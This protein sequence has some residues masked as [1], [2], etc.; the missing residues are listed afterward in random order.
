MPF[1]R[2]L[3]WAVVPLCLLCTPRWGAAKKI[4]NL[5]QI[6]YPSDA[7]IPWEC[8]TLKKGDSPLKLFG[9]R[10]PEVLRF[11]RIDRRH[12][13][14]GLSLKVP[15]DLEALADF[16]PLPR[17]Y[18]EAALAEKY[19]LVDL[20]E[21]YLGAYEYGQLRFS[22]PIASGG[23]ETPTPNGDF[24]ITAYHRDH[25]SSLYKIEKTDTPYPM[26]YALRFF[27]N[28]V[29]V[30]FWIHG[31]DVPGFPASHGCIGLYDE[32]MQH[33]YYQNPNK[34]ILQDVISLYAWLIGPRPDS[35]N[36]T[37]LKDGPPVKII[38]TPSGHAAPR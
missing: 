31:R 34:P 24:K 22:A 30:D 28:P 16:T 11:N 19:I 38:G 10:W 35:G 27:T 8:R 37:N 1:P 18:P 6:S 21:Q 2:Y 9:A 23:R 33:H 25:I 3:V 20:A 5:C 15:R 26:H 12:F 32:E 17:E 4:Y 7:A 14:S 36:L 13:G 29:G